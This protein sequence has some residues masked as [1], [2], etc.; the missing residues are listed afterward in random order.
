MS[1]SIAIGSA[2]SMTPDGQT[3]VGGGTTIY[4]NTVEITA[5]CPEYLDVDAIR[6]SNF[7]ISFADAGTDKSTLQLVEMTASNAGEVIYS[8]SRNGVVY[9]I[10]TISQ[11]DGV[12]VSIQQD[13]SADEDTAH[14]YA[15]KVLMDGSGFSLGQE[16]IYSDDP[17]SVNPLITRLTDNSFAMSYYN[18][19]DGEPVLSTRVGNLWI[20]MISDY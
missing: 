6:T 3:R 18:T 1:E 20:L 2:V 10:E 12:F 11:A 4:R 7:I 16:V 14:V 15:G 17:F 5:A 9:Q 13:M 8:A 19:V